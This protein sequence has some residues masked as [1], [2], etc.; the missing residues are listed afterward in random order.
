MEVKWWLPLPSFLGVGVASPR[1]FGWCCLASSFFWLCAFPLFLLWVVLL[2]LPT[3]FFRLVLLSPSL[4]AVVLF[5]FFGTSQTIPFSTCLS[6]V[7]VTNVILSF[8]QKSMS[9]KLFFHNL[10][11]TLKFALR[12]NQAEKNGNSHQAYLPT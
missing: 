2:L 5:F 7:H 9:R 4:L 12:K 10:T 8:E 11:E 6:V 1:A 3:S